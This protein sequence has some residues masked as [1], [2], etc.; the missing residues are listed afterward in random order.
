MRNSILQSTHSLTILLSCLSASTVFKILEPAL[1]FARLTLKASTTGGV[2]TRRTLGSEH[3]AALGGAPTALS[4]SSYAIRRMSAP[5]NT[6][7]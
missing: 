5:G 4:S 3:V 1:I 2:S 6:A 7:N